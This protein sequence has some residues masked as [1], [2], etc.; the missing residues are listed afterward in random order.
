MIKQKIGASHVEI[1]FSFV[2]FISFIIFIFIVFKPLNILSKTTTDLDAV[3]S[4][5]I[6][7]IS[8]IL[9]V[10]FPVRIDSS[11]YDPTETC[12][13]IGNP[14]NGSLTWPL[15]VKNKT[16]GIVN[17]S[18]KYG[19]QIY[20]ENSGDFYNIF[21][22][23]ELKERELSDTSSCSPLSYALGSEE[24]TIGLI[25]SY[26]VIS[27]SKLVE[28]KENYNNNYEQLK[29]ELGFEDDFVISIMNSPE[30]IFEPAKDKPQGIETLVRDVSILILKNNTDLNHDIMNIQVW[31]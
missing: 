29:Q 28:F 23:L 1:I 14:L 22:S 26:K 18:R 8:T 10:L 15:I 12:F 30:I 16:G 4:E 20:F 21:Y 11:I 6:K 9:S 7:N 13:Y 3:E 17:A 31:G 24:Y 5:I 25:R 27:Y 2:L 19:D